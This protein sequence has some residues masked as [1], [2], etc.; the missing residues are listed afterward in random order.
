MSAHVC[1]KSALSI[2]CILGEW[3]KK[4]RET[5]T[6]MFVCISSASS[7]HRYA[8]SV[9]QVCIFQNPPFSSEKRRVLMQTWCRT[10]A[11]FADFCRL[12]QTFCR[13][14]LKSLCLADYA[15]FCKVYTSAKLWHADFVRT[16]SLG[17]KVCIKSPT[18]SSKPSKNLGV[19][20]DANAQ[21]AYRLTSMLALRMLPPND[22]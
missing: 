9:H 3:H 5:Q 2:M 4:V 20:H 6:L 16:F 21:S 8:I 17:C 10:R 7:L 19:Q 14:F 12:L 1:I 18:C 15:D 22:A 11:D 13:L